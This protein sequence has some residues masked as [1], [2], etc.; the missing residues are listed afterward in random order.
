[1]HYR[2]L[3]KHGPTVPAIGL[4]FW[5]I[6]G[7]FGPADEAES[8]RT[9]G[10]AI[11]LG[12]TL[13]DTAPAYGSSE[14]LLGRTLGREREQ[15]FLTT[16]C[17]LAPDPRSGRLLLDSRPESLRRQVEDSL[18]RLRC[19]DVDLLL[20]HWPDPHVPIA[21]AAGALDRLRQTGLTRYVG[22]SNFSA[23]QLREAVHAAPIVCNQVGYHL[24]DR[25]WERAMFPTAAEL[26]VAVVAYSPLAHG[27]LTGTLDSAALHAD[28]WRTRGDTLS[29]QQLFAPANL[30]HNFA[31]ARQMAALVEQPG[32]SLTQA[33]IAWVLHQPQVAS[34]I[35]GSRRVA[36]LE[37]NIGALD[38]R[39]D[40]AT[41]A[42]LTRLGDFARGL[43]QDI[44]VWPMRSKPDEQSG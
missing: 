17:G 26:G 21:E 18:R 31:L 30:P 38:I 5:S 19:A 2:R 23:A 12:A 4:G 32:Q 22:V 37:E 40:D 34:V 41:R 1:M 11:E 44:P 42:E 36:R 29:S 39:L 13:F 35:T 20:I 33:A 9:M 27:L 15:V 25:R 16:K 7:A 43:E 14:E 8:R 24:F 28:D 3:G 10:R 6:G